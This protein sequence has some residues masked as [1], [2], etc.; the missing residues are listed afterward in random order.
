ML[1]HA[2]LSIQNNFAFPS[3]P[4]TYRVIKCHS[5]S[6]FVLHFFFVSSLVSITSP[7]ISHRLY[8]TYSSFP[9][10]YDGIIFQFALSRLRRHPSFLPSFLPL[11]AFL[12]PVCYVRT[13]NHTSPSSRQL[14]EAVKCLGS[15][16]FAHHTRAPSCLVAVLHVAPLT[17]CFRLAS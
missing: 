11:L 6:A 9:L 2:W 1:H 12:L 15:L 4:F 8:E 14:C 5:H 3:T 7:L 16:L 13:I 17:M 10:L